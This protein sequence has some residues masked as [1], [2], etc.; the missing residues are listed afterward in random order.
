MTAS[1]LRT[2]LVSLLTVAAVPVILGS[3]LLEEN[4]PY[5]KG[6]LT[7]VSQ[8][9]WRSIRGTSLVTSSDNH[10]HLP[11]DAPAESV[12]VRTF[13]R[14]A[15]GTSVEAS[16]LLRFDPP[17]PNSTDI[18]PSVFF[19]FTSSNGQ[20]RRGRLAFRISADGTALL[21]VTSRASDAITWA[22][23][24]LA[25][26]EVHFV[27]LRYDGASGHTALWINPPDLPGP[28]AAESLDP[29]TTPPARVSLQQNLRPGAP[30][31]RIS[32]LVV[33]EGG[34]AVASTPPASLPA[35]ATTPPTLSAG[36]T[37]PPPERFFLFLLLGQSNM[38][39]RGSPGPADLVSNPRILTLNPDGTWRLALD[40]LHF[41]KPSAGVGPGLPFAREL[42]ASLPPDAA[43]GLIP[44]AFG[45]S[46]IAWWNKDYSGQQ[47]WPNGHNYYQHAVNAARA[48]ATQGRL[49]G[50]LWNQGESDQGRARGDEGEDYRRRLHAL[51]ADLRADL[52]APL[53][54]FVAATLGPWHAQRAI[55][56]N[57]VVLAL[58]VQVPQTAT[59]NTLAPEV[60]D[61]LRN[62]TDDP[63]HYDTPSYHLLGRLYARALLPLL[64]PENL[65]A[66]PI[67][68]LNQPHSNYSPAG[69]RRPALPSGKVGPSCQTPAISTIFGI[70]GMP[71]RLV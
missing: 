2:W 61:Q 44:A 10:A 5:Q 69:G 33:R 32:R 63:S 27:R 70:R 7:T 54:P 47:R 39:G 30:N 56:F 43:I 48:A 3:P 41:D 4:F 14:P 62:K 17:S 37:L 23:H 24:E 45:G 29:N 25:P 6:L 15:A 28:P 50:I 11:G 71:R 57:S 8:G 67:R 60:L 12:L 66:P 34:A 52:N 19:Q 55:A 42:L 9:E 36:V 46:S 40:P 13:T 58:P 65:R 26:S 20:L 35:P 18:A 31:L 1:L 21:G 59:V 38:A 53:L 68:P 64:T 16:F 49:T 51:I 22:S